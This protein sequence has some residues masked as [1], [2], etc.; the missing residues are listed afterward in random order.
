MT[1]TVREKNRNIRKEALREWLSKQGL[2]QRVLVIAKE[3]GDESI[4]MDQTVIARKRAAA[5]LNLKLIAKYVPDARDATDLNVKGDIKHSRGRDEIE[6]A[7]RAKGIDPECLK[8][9]QH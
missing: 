6:S 7:L 4:E 9:T 5:D 8:L 1:I 3:L 2:A